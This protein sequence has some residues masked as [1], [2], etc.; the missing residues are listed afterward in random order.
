MTINLLRNFKSV[1]TDSL[2]DIFEKD[3][4]CECV[5]VVYNGLTIITIP[6]VKLNTTA[7]LLQCIDVGVHAGRAAKLVLQ[8][9]GVMGWGYVVMCQ[10]M[11]HVLINFVVVVVKN[12]SFG[13][14][15]VVCQACDEKKK[16]KIGIRKFIGNMFTIIKLKRTK[17]KKQTHKSFWAKSTL[18][19]IVESP[20]L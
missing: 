9:I 8:K 14:F 19:N 10:R 18:T 5:S 7:S 4:R 2:Y 1:F 3:F 12:V 13:W 20:F 16:S 15:K 6:A 11:S 17:N